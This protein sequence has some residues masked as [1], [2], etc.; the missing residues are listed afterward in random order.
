MVSKNSMSRPVIGPSAFPMGFPDGR[1]AFYQ[2]QSAQF[3]IY[4]HWTIRTVNLHA[5]G[6]GPPIIGTAEAG[7]AEA[8]VSFLP[9]E[10][11]GGSAIIGYTATSSPDGQTGT[12]TESPLHSQWTEQRHGLHLHRLRGRTIPVMV[13]NRPLP[14]R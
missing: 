2:F 1:L 10:D 6:S 4:D 9:P 7:N 8:S 14:M 3:T 5:C 13:R 12:C 11:T